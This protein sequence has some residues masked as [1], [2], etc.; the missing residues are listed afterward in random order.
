MNPKVARLN[1]F[2]VLCASLAIV[3][4]EKQA[5][6][7]V[8]NTSPVQSLP[9]ERN[10]QPASQPKS[11]MCTFEWLDSKKQADTWAT[12]SVAFR[13]ELLPDQPSAD[14]NASVYPLKQ[15]ARM[16]R[17]GDAVFVVLEK[18]ATEKEREE[19][20][21]PFDLYNFNLAKNEK[22]P[23]A[24]KWI[25]W[26]WQFDQLAHF[27]DGPAPDITFRS[28]SCVE[29]EPLIILSA[30]RFDP[31]AQKWELRHWLNR[32]EGITIADWDL[33][34]GS[35]GD[36]ET[37]AGIADFSKKG[38]DE[39]AVWTLNR[40]LDDKDPT[41][42]LPAV[43]KVSL[44]GFQNGMPVEANVKDEKEISRI[45]KL[46]C[47]IALEDVACKKPVAR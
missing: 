22:T 37:L 31:K 5:A 9:A 23:I 20:D 35:E 6:P 21:R 10:V 30:V 25:F 34:E 14:P 18:R 39:V 16:A 29:C 47:E 42:T 7:A 13:Q 19:W 33:S 12:V 4:S 45:K 2:G 26:F 28:M 24:A 40:S 8:Q 44:F 17:C 3:A 38:H 43:T 36:Y 41:K 27:E 46:L 1:V 15:I 32:E 11:A